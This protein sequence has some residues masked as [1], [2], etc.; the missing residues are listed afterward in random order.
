MTLD[1]L[2]AATAGDHGWVLNW[3]VILGMLTG[4]ATVAV[5]WIIPAVTA[6]RGNDREVI[7]DRGRRDSSI[8]RDN[9]Q[10]S[11]DRVVALTE[12]LTRIEGKMDAESQRQ[13]EWRVRMETILGSRTV[14]FTEMTQE[15]RTLAEEMAKLVNIVDGIKEQV[16]KIEE[17][18]RGQDKAIELVLSQARR[19]R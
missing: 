4:V 15:T 18:G 14:V 8:G 13:T 3:T 12:D 2:Q 1:L 16:D 11:R 17:R 5:K 9:A 19:K 7:I 6:L 10:E